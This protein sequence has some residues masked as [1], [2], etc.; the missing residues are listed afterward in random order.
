MALNFSQLV[1]KTVHIGIGAGKWIEVPML[2]ME[3]YLCFREI[4]KRISQ[5]PKEMPEKEQAEKLVEAREEMIEMVQKVLPSPLKENIYRLDFIQ[6][7]ALILVL[8]NGNDNSEDDDPEK[9][10]N[11]EDITKKTVEEN[12]EQKSITIS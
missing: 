10:T 9:K 11:P 4:Q 12:K 1:K 7:T 2:C 3:D 5:L 8:C 6:L